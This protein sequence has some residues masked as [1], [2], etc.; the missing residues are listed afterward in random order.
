V[1]LL[2]LLPALGWTALIAWFSTGDWG[3]AETGHFL[4]PL[5]ARVLPWLAPEQLDALHWL[6]RKSAHAGEYAVLA[7]L[8]RWAL[9]TRR[10]LRGVVIPL[11]LSV[12]TAALDELHQTFTLTRTG[13]FADVLLDSAAAS[14]ALIVS[15]VGLHPTVEWLTTALLWLAAAGGTGLL[16]VNWG[17][18]A[19]SGWLWWSVP[20]AW[21]AL[22]AWLVRRRQG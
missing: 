18:G 9:T 14:G 2:R 15:S 13:S 7:T 16:A 12:L 8:W 4:L 3:A 17:A 10:S 21:I 5:L 1:S 20:A 19:P 6:A 11:G 22:G